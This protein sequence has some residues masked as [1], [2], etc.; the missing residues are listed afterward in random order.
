MCM[1]RLITERIDPADGRRVS[2]AG[3][4]SMSLDM[5]TVEPGDAV[6]RI[7]DGVTLWG[8][9]LSVEDIATAANTIPYTLILWR[10]ITR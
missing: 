10:D 6:A 2:L 4:V 8:D 9:G 7:G 1:G 3:P 5:I